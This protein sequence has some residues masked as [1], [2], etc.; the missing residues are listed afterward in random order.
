MRALRPWLLVVVAHVSGTPGLIC[1]RARERP[2]RATGYPAF[3][4]QRSGANA[5]ISK[6][7]APCTGNAWCRAGAQDIL[8]LGFMHFAKSVRPCLC[9]VTLP[10]HAQTSSQGRTLPQSY[11]GERTV[12]AICKTRSREKW[13]T[14]HPW[15][16]IRRNTA[17]C[18]SQYSLPCGRDARTQ[19]AGNARFMRFSGYFPDMTGDFS[20]GANGISFERWTLSLHLPHSSLI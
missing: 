3:A 2:G 18:V 13:R 17:P 14:V 8:C 1:P 5:S 15:G 19:P 16:Q 10:A 9:V 6:R 7:C 4:P 11:A 20:R 12:S